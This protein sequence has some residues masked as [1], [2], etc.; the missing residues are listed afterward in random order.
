MSTINFKN[1]NFVV[2]DKDIILNKRLNLDIAYFFKT[3]KPSTKKESLQ[4]L[5]EKINY[6]HTQAQKEN[7]QTLEILSK[8][9]FSLIY[10]LKEKY[11][12]EFV[13][14]TSPEQ[15]KDIVPV[16]ELMSCENP[17]RLSLNGTLGLSF[18]KDGPNTAYYSNGFS[19]KY[20]DKLNPELRDYNLE[21]EIN[22]QISELITSAYVVGQSD[23]SQSDSLALN[24][25]ISE[26]LD[27]STQNAQTLKET[28][29]L[30]NKKQIRR[31]SDINKDIEDKVLIEISSQ[32][33]DRYITL[34]RDNIEKMR[35]RSYGKNRLSRL[36]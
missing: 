24:S 12:F 26:A 17:E 29:K 20:L 5:K 19:Q 18:I 9:D 16:L 14:F 28:P 25:Y 15:I 8:V 7:Q 11:Q 22:E 34:N 4:D 27:I 3:Y 2:L 6:I 33:T 1:N 36:H 10:E 13:E 32:N 23:I 35:E 21:Q 30:A 31:D